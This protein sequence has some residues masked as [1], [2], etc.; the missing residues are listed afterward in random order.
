MYLYCILVFKKL[1][2]DYLMKCIDTLVKQIRVNSI[3]E[4]TL[5]VN[6]K[7]YMKQFV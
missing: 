1:N 7:G 4:T 2:F 6:E 5:Q 3:I